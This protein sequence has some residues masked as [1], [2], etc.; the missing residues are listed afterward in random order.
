MNQIT[1]RRSTAIS[2]GM[3]GFASASSRT[4]TTQPAAPHEN[5]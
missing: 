1:A 4:V 5:F 3:P 2:L